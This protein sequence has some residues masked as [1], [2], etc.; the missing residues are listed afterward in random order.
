MSHCSVTLED[1]SI[2]VAGGSAQSY[3]Y[4]SNLTEVYNTTTLQWERRG[5]MQHGRMGHACA[6]VWLDPQPPVG[7]GIIA[8][9][10]QHSSILSIIAAGGEIVYH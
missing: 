9:T 6:S 7:D 3:R 8:S 2:I 1:G 4:G 5:G 10:V